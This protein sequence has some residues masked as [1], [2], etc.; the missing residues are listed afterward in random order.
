[1]RGGRERSAGRTRAINQQQQPGGREGGYVWYGIFRSSPRRCNTSAQSIN[2]SGSGHRNCDTLHL[3]SPHVFSI[4]H[5]TPH[6]VTPSNSLQSY[7][8][9]PPAC[10][11][12][13]LTLTQRSIP[14][15]SMSLSSGLDWIRTTLENPTPLPGYFPSQPNQFVPSVTS[16]SLPIFRSDPDPPPSPRG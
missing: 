11:Y 3:H 10:I 5:S 2:G 13:S 15:I 14:G 12:T 9:H 6:S 8:L 1:M 16:S 4:C 7:R